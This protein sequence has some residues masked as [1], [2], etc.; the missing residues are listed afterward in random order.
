M[1]KANIFIGRYKD[2]EN[3]L[4]QLLDYDEKNATVLTYLAFVY[5]KMDTKDRGK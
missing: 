5:C 3:S 2:A 1:A 4:L